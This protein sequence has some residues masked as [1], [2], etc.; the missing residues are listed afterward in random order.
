MNK[1]E[2]QGKLKSTTTAFLFWFFLAAHF[3]YLGKWGIQILF[4]ITI[5]GLGV[6]WFIEVFLIS[7]RIQ[8][9]NASIYQQLDELDKREKADDLAKNIAMI[10]ASKG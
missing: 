4:W 3:A 10:K 8:K 9:Y 7:G 1:Y 6:W 2:L 5:G